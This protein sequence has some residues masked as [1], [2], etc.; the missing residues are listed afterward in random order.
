M[1]CLPLADDCG[2]SEKGTEDVMRC[3]DARSL[4]GASLLA[5]GP[6]AE[7]AAAMM[8]RRLAAD[9]GLRAGAHL[10][11]LEGKCSAPPSS[12]PLLAD[13][14]GRF[15]H[16]LG[17]LCGRLLVLPAAEKEKI[18]EQTAREWLAQVARIRDLLRNA[19]GL[20]EVPLYLDGHQHVHA[21][22]A[23]RPAL[24]RVLEAFRFVHVRSPEEPR[25]A[26]P[27]PLS[28]RLVGTARRELL[29]RWGAGLRRFLT[30]RGVPVPDFFIGGMC[31]GSMT[32]PRLE[33][34]LAAVYA[35][36][37]PTDLVEIMFHP[38]GDDPGGDGKDVFSA[39][40]AAPERAVEKN[41]LLSREYRELLGACDPE[42][43]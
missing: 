36:A 11:L 23:L 4:R 24:A 41:L 18:I 35:R 39:F 29:A 31:S 42:W 12:V 43:R 16:T 9:P 25:Y 8:G 7:K 15:R 38:G 21:V 34:G 19:S 28:L 37:R 14:S 27:A 6:F 10:N 1:R 26:C 2:I 5:N 40:Y 17:G 20:Q 30:A 13:A 22:P 32:G 33:A 3:I